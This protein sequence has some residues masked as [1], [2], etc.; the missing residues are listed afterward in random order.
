MP[1]PTTTQPASRPTNRA[2][3]QSDAD[4]ARADLAQRLKVDSS[5]VQV[6]SVSR[7]PVAIDALRCGQN[8]KQT[9]PVTLPGLVNAT[10]IVLKAGDQQYTYYVRGG[11]LIACP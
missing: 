3:A 5:V 9:P 7:E 8:A 2:T 1:A 4:R 10:E 11:Q 6:V